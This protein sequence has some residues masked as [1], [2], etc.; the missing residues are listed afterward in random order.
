MTLAEQ[1]AREHVRWCVNQD[2]R[3]LEQVI[4]EVAGKLCHL[5]S[6]T[7]YDAVRAVE[8]AWL[9]LQCGELLEAA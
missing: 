9:G 6:P 7:F 4:Q 1:I 5:G 2:G 8:I 3:S